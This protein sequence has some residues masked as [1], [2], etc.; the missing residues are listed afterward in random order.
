MTS[1]RRS[2]AAADFQEVRPD[3][4]IIHNPAVGPTLR[5]EGERQGDRF[6]LTTWRREG[7]IARLRSRQ[8]VV[9]TLADQI[10]ELRDLPLA[11][12]AGPPLPRPLA[13]GERVSYFAA[14]PLGWQPAPAA[15]D[16]S[17]AVLL[18]QGWVIRRRKGRG[19]ASY[20]VMLP[21]ALRSLDEDAALRQ[22]YAQ[23]TADSPEPVLL[24]PAEG[25]LLLPD[26]P[27]P[28]AHRHV[29][30]RFA[31]RH[32]DEWLLEAGVVPLAIA[33][34]ARLGLTLIAA[35]AQ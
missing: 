18:R 26:L 35:P 15:P 22:A 24:R 17:Q 29:L 10:A 9:S 7:L 6:R 21:G 1:K 4:F 23:L 11:V 13:A 31:K 12:P 32:G 30:G 33:L 19:P 28:E 27:L 25:G 16:E 2:W 5:G 34:L 3:L 14:S 8:F 20:A